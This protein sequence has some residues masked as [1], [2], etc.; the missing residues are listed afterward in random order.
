MEV[1]VDINLKE[2]LETLN[3]SNF[4]NFKL[5]YKGLKIEIN[6]KSPVEYI[7]VL[8][9]EETAEVEKLAEKSIIERALEKDD[10]LLEDWDF[11]DGADQCELL[12]RGLIQDFGNGK[13]VY[14]E[15]VN[16]Q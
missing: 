9:K 14:N 5:S 6:D 13:R 4:K 16:A 15:V 3:K 8:S 2:L 11:L 12:D 1:Y 10:Q 7:P